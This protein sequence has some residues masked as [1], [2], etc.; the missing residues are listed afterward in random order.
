MRPGNSRV[1]WVRPEVVVEV[2]YLT[3][4]EGGLLRA[5]L[6]APL[7]RAPEAVLSR[8]A[9]ALGSVAYLPHRAQMETGLLRTMSQ[10][11]TQP[12]ASALGKQQQRHLARPRPPL[13]ARSLGGDHGV[14]P[15]HLLLGER[16]INR[17]AARLGRGV[18]LVQA[19]DGGG[20]LVGRQLGRDALAHF[21]TRGDQTFLHEVVGARRAGKTRAQNAD[22]KAEA[23]R[24]HRSTRESS[25]LPAAPSRQY[26]GHVRRFKGLGWTHLSK[27]SLLVD[28]PRTGVRSK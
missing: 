19:V 6:S 10:P 3:W 26:R 18:G 21:L 1:H 28:T 27:A 15:L 9:V 25:P 2:T 7:Q 17:V 5:V 4:I 13:H 8:H 20:A 16:Q 14:E 24:S 22:D 11:S 12:S 23:H